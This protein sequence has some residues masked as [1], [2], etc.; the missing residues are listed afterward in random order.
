MLPLSG[1]ADEAA[2]DIAGQIAAHRELGWSALELRLLHGKQFASAAVTEDE[3]ARALAAIQD[4][5]L[6]VS[7]FASAIGNWS[8]PIN[9]DFAV[10]LADLRVLIPRMQKAGTRFV[11]TMGWMQAGTSDQVWRDEGIR[12][13]REMA[14]LA[15]DADIVLLHENCEGWGGTSPDHAR[16]FMEAVAHPNVRYLFDIG[17]T[18]SYGLP[19]LPFYEAVRPF[20]AYVHVKDARRNPAG[21]KSNA[22]TYPGQGD[23]L[24]REILADL[25]RRGYTAGVSIEPHVASIVHLGEGTKASPEERFASY[26]RYGHELEALLRSLP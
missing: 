13:Y 12:R 2:D 25:V 6:R 23:A 10:D 19:T 20:I 15:A 18:V 24:V 11:R 21:G 14:K 1:L 7:G 16:A 3:F 8:R 5:G 17:N 9:G 26:V 4:A 22:F